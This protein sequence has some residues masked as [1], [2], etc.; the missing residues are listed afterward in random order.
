M[1]RTFASLHVPVIVI[2]IHELTGVHR[3]Q[4]FVSDTEFCFRACKDGPNA[5]ALCNHIYD[6]MGCDWNMPGNYGTGFDQCLGDDGAVSHY[7]IHAVDLPLTGAAFVA[8]GR[9]WHLD[10]LP[11]RPRHAGRAAS[12]GDVFVHYNVDHWE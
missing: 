8:D 11:G 10:V 4:N 5:P 3:G 7:S 1:D 6:L 12:W 9:V 2:A